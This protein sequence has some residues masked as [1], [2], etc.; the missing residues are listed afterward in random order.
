M[1]VVLTV[2]LV[3]ILAAGV[4][5][6]AGGDGSVV[7]PYQITTCTELQAMNTHLNANYVLAN[8]IACSDTINWNSG[9]GFVPI[10]WF[11]G[12]FDGKG[13][14]ITSLVINRP[15]ES[16]VGLFSVIT[17][18]A[19]IK[20]VG[21]VDVI[22]TGNQPVGGLV[23]FNYNGEITDSYSTGSVIG[24]GDVGGLVGQNGGKITSSHTTGSVQ[25]NSYYSNVGGLVGIN[26]INGNIVGPGTITDSYST[27]SVSGGPYTFNIGGLVGWNYFGTITSSYATGSVSGSQNVGGLVGDNYRGT[28][29]NSY[30]TGSVS[31]G[32]QG[33]SGGLVGT[34]DGTITNSYATGSVSGS[35]SVSLGGLVGK[36][37]GATAINSYWNTETSGRPTSAGG[38]GETTV[39]MKTQST[40]VD[41]DFA[42]IWAIN[43]TKNNGYPYFLWQIPPVVD[44]DGDGVVDAI[45]N[46]PNVPNA[47][48]VDTDY[49]GI[50]DACDPQICGNGVVE[51]GEECDDDNLVNGDGCSSTC[52]VEA[53]ACPSGIVSYW[54]FDEGSG[55]TAADSVGT[56]PRTI[57]GATWTSGKVGSALAFDGVDDSAGQYGV[58]GFPRF[59]GILDTFTTELWVYPL[60]T[61]AV[62]TESTSTHSKDGTS[63]QR[64]AIGAE[65][66]DP[67]CS[68]VGSINQDAGSGISV[69][70]NGISVFEHA[71]EYMP[72]LLVYNTALTGWNHIVVVYINKQPRL[73]L[74]GILVR[75]GLTSP[76]IVRPS[77]EQ[78]GAGAYGFFSGAI[79]EVAIYDRSLTAE[80]IQQHYQNGLAGQGTE[81][82]Q[83][84]A[85]TVG[86]GPCQNTGTQ[87]R[88]CGISGW[89]DWGTCS[90][91]AGSPTAETCNGID[92]NCD[93][94]VDN[95]LTLP[96][97]SCT[98]GVGACQNTG[99]QEK[100]CGGIFGWSDWGS[101]SVSPGSPTG[102]DNNCNGIDENCDGTADNVYTPTTTNC[103]IGACA[104]TGQLIC[105]NGA[106]KDTC[107]AGTPTTETCDN[108]DNDCDSITDEDLTR[109]TACG[110][111]ACG[112]TGTATCAAGLWVGDTCTAGI[113]TAETC[114]G[115]DNDCD[116]TVDESLT[117]TT[118]CGL[119][120]CSSNTGKETCTA[121]IWEGNTCNPLAGA[122]TE[123]CDD[124]DN[125]CDGKTDESPCTAATY[126]SNINIKSIMDVSGM[127]RC[128][129]ADWQKNEKGRLPNDCRVN[130]VGSGRSLKAV[131]VATTNAN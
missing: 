33:G 18:S 54:N 60:S 19:K 29:T 49:D 109:G 84:Q 45:D 127:L 94:I 24:N 39:E 21:L 103:G 95:G 90:A 30:A 15:L 76:R 12:T 80:E 8:D 40:F 20:N 101:C 116:G 89:S 16:N 34:N 28:I 31:G 81:I 63:G 59:S 55:S 106:T 27:G 100:T 50:G 6:F 71:C 74:N 87:A 110:I 17:A 37:N 96:T 102:P 112:S 51:A 5:A 131:C 61:R 22:I 9:A 23:G 125:D 98:V 75:T 121:G 38:T 120:V 62:T 119:G 48:Q 130:F 97:Q 13:Y 69:G 93:G 70:T 10:G 108:I 2:F 66:G 114:D 88:T 52:T 56:S 104:A 83:N 86:V 72:S 46:C 25:S 11:T 73:Y 107:T 44:S 78:I 91:I 35:G 43:P 122:T 79:D 124:K 47:D 115:K 32:L 4:S 64:Y 14:K 26:Y 117:R 42:N 1:F 129:I 123:V 99:T 118:R 77:K 111:G 65:P 57:H 126:C 36:N 41:W 58:D 3:S 67:G 82:S 85:C 53:A 105:D 128:T 68:M 113:P 92:D 7:N